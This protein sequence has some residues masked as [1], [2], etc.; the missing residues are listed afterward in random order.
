MCGSFIVHEI[1]WRAGGDGLD[2]SVSGWVF[3]NHCDKIMSPLR[4]SVPAHAMLENAAILHP[5][6][7]N[8]LPPARPSISCTNRVGGISLK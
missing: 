2:D 4:G 8:R 5:R 7:P 3:S 1:E 6:T